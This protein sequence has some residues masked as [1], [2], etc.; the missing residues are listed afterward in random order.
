MIWHSED[1][2]FFH[3]NGGKSENH[4]LSKYTPT[5]TLR[6]MSEIY[7]CSLL[8]TSCFHGHSNLII[9]LLLMV[10]ITGHTR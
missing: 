1:D 8:H 10:V 9:I 7:H 5:H 4:T 2:G 6:H 3:M